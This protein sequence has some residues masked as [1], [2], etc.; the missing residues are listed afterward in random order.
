MATNPPTDGDLYLKMSRSAA[1]HGVGANRMTTKKPNPPTARELIEAA[2][3]ATRIV[4]FTVVM[5]LETHALRDRAEDSFEKVLVA[6]E[7]VR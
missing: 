2:K 3:A 5:S 1:A 4:P 7:S 6:L